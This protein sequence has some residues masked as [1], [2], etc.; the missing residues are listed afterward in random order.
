MGELASFRQKIDQIDEQILELLNERAQL[1]K[2]IGHVKK[3]T[4][5]SIL[6]SA[7]E[8]SVLNRLVHLN[9]GPL[10]HSN[11]KSIYAEI[12]SQFKK[13]Q[14][15]PI[16]SQLKRKVSVVGMGLMGGSLYK[17]LRFYH[18][19]C[20]I[21]AYDM[22]PHPEWPCCEF[23][24]IFDSDYIFLAMPVD[25]IMNFLTQN[26][27]KFRAGTTLVDLGSTKYAIQETAQS[28]L[29]THVTYL[30]GHPLVGKAD[31]GFE[32][33]ERDLFL[34]TTFIISTDEDSKL[35]SE[36]RTL[37]EGIGLQLKILN[38][39]DHDHDLAYFSHLPHLI[40]LA[41]ALV[42]FKKFN[43][44]TKNELIPRSLREM[45]RIAF[46]YFPVWKDIYKTNRIEIVKAIEEFQNSLDSLKVNINDLSSQYEFVQKFKTMFNRNNEESEHDRSNEE[47][48]HKQSVA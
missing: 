18:P 33:S 9:Q 5:A 8:K 46:A 38:A 43:L 47:K 45:T 28:C 27:T 24:E 48:P 10:S 40:S 35:N 21:K 2:R 41:L 23:S 26:S 15:R 31:S 3:Q 14:S 19:A 36:L 20:E 4:G 34:N 17:A 42:I 30:G 7:R 6:N 22:Q 16:P 39:K 32:H 44:N 37:L 13:I 1:A 29:P 12:F 25:A 11:I